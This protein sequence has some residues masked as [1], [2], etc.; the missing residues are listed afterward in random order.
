MAS[1]F[2]EVVLLVGNSGDV[3]IL[4]SHAFVDECYCRQY[5]PF[6]DIYTNV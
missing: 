2:E 4:K 6:V 1:R 5:S 3:T